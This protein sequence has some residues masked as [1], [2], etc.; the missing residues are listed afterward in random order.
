MTRDQRTALGFAIILGGIV[1]SSWAAWWFMT[2][3]DIIQILHE[4]KVSLPGWMWIVMKVG[5]SLVAG[6]FVI[7]FFLILAM[8]LFRVS[9]RG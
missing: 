9:D 2:V 8:L 5:L 6:G 4:I 1:L 3:G 7:L